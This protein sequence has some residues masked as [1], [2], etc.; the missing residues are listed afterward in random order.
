MAEF[1]VQ[2]GHLSVIDNKFQFYRDKVDLL[3][4][5]YVVLQ[6]HALNKPRKEDISNH[7]EANQ[8]ISTLNKLI[9][10]LQQEQEGKSELFKKK[11][12]EYIPELNTCIDNL[13][14]ESVEPQYFDKANMDKEKIP[15]ILAQLDAKY[16]LL[17]QYTETSAKYNDW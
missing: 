7:T 12:N 4:Q 8:M 14:K 13:M 3:G 16:E 11:L 15:E 17:K 1:V 2:Q 6:E 10:D 9:S 5:F